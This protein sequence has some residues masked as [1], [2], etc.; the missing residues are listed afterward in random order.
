MDTISLNYFLEAAKDLNF[1][2]TA[3]R[4]FISQ[5]NLS[6]HIARLEQHYDVL[7]FERKPKLA[8]TYSGEVVLS[9]ANK[10]CM[11]EDNLNNDLEVIKQ[12]NIG[13]LH[14]G[15]SPNRTSIVMP[16][17][18]GKFEEKYPNV[19]LNLYHHHSTMHTK[20]LFSGE[21]DFAI[22]VDKFTNP[23]L[24]STVLFKDSVYIMV[25]HSIL[26]KHFGADTEKVINEFKGGAEINRFTALPFVNVRSSEL[27]NDVFKSAECTPN[28]QLTSNYPQFFFPNFHHTNSVAASIITKVTYYHIKD[29]LPDDIHVFPIITG[30]KFK[31]HNIAF[32]RNKGKKLSQF[33][34]HF[35]KLAIEH[36]SKME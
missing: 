24:V 9:Y 26:K 32:I 4:L 10:I 27:M 8:L 15:C 1:T 16:Y 29:T 28:F 18:M 14:I 36:F 7:L 5:Q 30:E 35:S 2:H 13:C 19:K 3:K 11:Q 17:L 6:N 23:N 31:I 12:N 21:L 20:M 34:E 22:G 25:S 33:G